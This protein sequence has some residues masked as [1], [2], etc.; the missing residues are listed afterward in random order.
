MATDQNFETEVL[1]AQS[2]VVVDF[3]AEW[4]GPCKRLEPIVAELAKE[5]EGKAKIMKLDI[6]ASPETASK[7]AVLSVPTVLFFKGGQKVDTVV[8]LTAKDNLKKRI[9]ALLK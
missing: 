8:G 9:D 5:Y 3:G 4:C 2:P 6:D 1:Q 7:Y